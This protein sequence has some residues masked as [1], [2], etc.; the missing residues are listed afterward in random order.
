MIKTPADIVMKDSKSNKFA[1]WGR[2]AGDLSATIRLEKGIAIPNDDINIKISTNANVFAIG[3]CF[4]RNIESALISED[5]SVL[6]RNIEIP[7]DCPGPR[8]IDTLNKYN[9]GSIFHEL[10][11]ALGDTNFDIASFQNI[12][13]SY[14]DLNLKS[15]TPAQ[16]LELCKSFRNTVNDYFKQ[17]INADVVIITLGMIECWRDEKLDLVLNQPPHPKAIKNEPER[18][19]FC[20]MELEDVLNYMR[21][22]IALIN[23]YGNKS[24]FITTSPVALERTFT[25]QD[26]IV[27]NCISKSTLRVACDNLVKDF[28]NVYYYPSYE[29][30][31]YSNT[32]LAWKPDLLHASDY[33]VSRII[34][35]FVVRHIDKHTENLEVDSQG[36][37]LSELEI[38]KNQVGKYKALLEKNNLL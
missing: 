2:G 38:L 18:F 15:K 3:S 24:I 30:V 10:D 7:F 16:T 6:S 5:I 34:N 28:N 20:I 23:K 13:E 8:A 26:V 12:N 35:Q 14:T 37:H 9:A 21:K 32:E 25:N 4:A 19:T 31:I 29:T 17:I 36:N 27:A 1:K 22:S 11:W 33:I